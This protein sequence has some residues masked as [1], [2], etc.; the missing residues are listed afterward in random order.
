MLYDI[1]AIQYIYGA[2]MTTRAGNTVYSFGT[3][4][5]YFECIWDAGGRDTIDLSQQ[6]RN[7]L[8]NLTAGT[9]SSI[10]IKTNGQTASG[11]VAIAFNCT[12]EDAVGGAGHDRISGNGVANWLRGGNGNDTVAGGAGNDRLE[13]GLGADTMDGGSGDDLYYVD[14]VSDRAETDSSTGFDRIKSTA[15]YTLAGNSGV[16]VLQL[17]GGNLTATGNSRANTLI[18]S[19][20]NNILN[21]GA[22]ADTMKGGS[23][24]DR[25]FV[26]DA[27]DWVVETSSGGID[28]VFASVSY[29]L[30]ANVEKLTLQGHGQPNGTGNNLN[31]TI[32]GNGGNNILDGA[33]GADT[34]VGGQGDDTYIVD[35]TRD[36]V[37]ELAGGRVDTIISSLNYNLGRWANVEKL[38]LAEGTSAFVGIGNAANNVMTG[39]ANNNSLR[40][41]SGND[42]LIGNDGDDSLNGE[43]G[44]DRLWGGNHE[45]TLTGGDGNDL[46][47]GG[48]GADS[49]SG[50]DGLDTFDYNA[51]SEAGDTIA[52]FTTGAGGDVLD[53][54]DL[55][56]DFADPADA[57]AGGYL[58]F[59]SNGTDTLVRVDT[60]GGMDNGTLLATL[61]SVQLTQGDIDNYLV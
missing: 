26:H 9:F 23:G 39:N 1:L 48:D 57:F 24:A 58:A 34:L 4:R 6:T 31:N 17:I 27:G 46:L 16:E 22:G 28:T 55:L 43:A 19:A 29:T 60:D 41:A 20:G 40:G 52:D 54:T 35:S 11:N 49:L 8:I 32:V 42:T 56:I 47:V 33:A 14:R 15:S 5:E 3:G 10:G 12:I 50:G 18:G 13:G 7:Q 44:H 61:T 21:G 37:Q 59:E 38:V 45:D 25:Y 30:A 53:L 36:V 2:N 51:L